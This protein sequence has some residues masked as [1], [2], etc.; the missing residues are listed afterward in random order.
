MENEDLVC[1]ACG[2]DTFATGQLGHGKL[3]TESN[4]RPVGS[5]INSGSPLTL[6]F[7]KNC[8]EVVS[9]KVSKPE[10]FK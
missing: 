10:K 2:N 9:F 3:S 4:V 6:S 8:G 7:C 5:L 1:R